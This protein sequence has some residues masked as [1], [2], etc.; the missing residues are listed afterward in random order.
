MCT[1][2]IQANGCVRIHVGIN[3]CASA[4][5]CVHACAGSRLVLDVFLDCLHFYIL[6]FI[7]YS[8]VFHTSIT[9]SDNLS[10]LVAVEIPWS[11]SELVGN[12]IKI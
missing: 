10:R 6:Y 3:V 5:V 2:S 1:Y 8:R 9:E 4:C 11:W 12:L 7:P